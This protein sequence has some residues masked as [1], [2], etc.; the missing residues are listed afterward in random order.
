MKN[1]RHTTKNLITKAILA[2]MLATPLS[3]YAEDDKSKVE[4]LGFEV[5]TVTAQKRVQNIMNVPVTVGTISAE[6]M[7][8]SGSVRLTEMDKFIPGF[9]FGNEGITQEGVSM[10]GVESSGISI[11][12]DPSAA[13]FFD[14]VYMPRA[15]Q[16]LL[17]SDMER[18]EVL[19]GPQGTLFGRNAA[20]GVL[21]MV[22]N[23]PHEDFEATIKATLGTDNL[24]RYELMANIPLSDNVYLRTNYINTSRDGVAENI[25]MPEWNHNNKIWDAGEVAHQSA[26]ASLLWDISDNSQ[27][28]ISY[29]W[30]DLNQ[31]PPMTIGISEYA[32][33]QGDPFAPKVENDVVGGAETRDMTSATV[34]FLHE[35]NND[36]SMKYIASFR[37]WEVFARRDE[38]GTADLSRYFDTINH[39]EAD[40]FY[41]ELQFN[42]ET[43]NINSVFGF[44][45]SK[46]SAKQLTHIGLTADSAARS[47][48]ASVND[49]IK[50]GVADQLTNTL[51][52]NTDAHAAGAFGE[53]VT[54]DSVLNAIYQSSGFPIESTWHAEEWEHTLNTMGFGDTIMTAIGMPG[55]PLTAGVVTA[56]GDATYDIASVAL[57]TAE[58]FGPSHSGSFWQENVQNQGD[59]TNWGIYA[60]V[61]YMINDK[62]SI[63]GGLRYSKDE[64]EFSWLTEDSS[65]ATIRPGVSNLIFPVVD[66]KAKDSWDKVTGRLVA[67]YQVSNEHMVFG[68]YSVGYKSGGYDSLT[69]NTQAFKPED[70]VNYELGYKGILFDA[71]I[72][73]VSAYYNQLDN[74]QKGIVSKLPGNLRAIPT[75]INIDREIIGLEID[76]RWNMTE[77]AQ[78]GLVT[79]IR[80]TDIYTPSFYNG[81]GTLIEEQSTDLDAAANVTMTLDWVLDLGIGNTN[82][83]VDY[84]YIENQN[85]QEVGLEEYK[86]S[87]DAYFIDTKN[88]NARFSWTSEDD[89]LEIGLWGKNLLDKRYVYELG[90]YAADALGVPQGQI[91]RGLEAGVDV[92]YSF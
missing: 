59:F 45:Y 74:Q 25:S 46:E 30:D 12:G 85:D 39:E 6:L 27:F 81:E 47:I 21:N 62:W 77:D 8:E 26:R 73:N 80:S 90:G 40:I 5:I 72:A 71:V 36:L 9:E 70:S 17:F 44:S 11:G 28:Q 10:R 52:G 7:E 18:I 42:Y 56:T 37:E 3:A 2:S 84:V 66:L 60:D 53:G 75:I 57:G 91:N 87:V 35:F 51:G 88:L 67:S 13:T 23:R 55:Q 82:L 49:L 65:F 1:N 31:A 69:P 92:T 83:H 20:V 63:I 33:G 78:L 41:T 15:A 50:A 43:D 89:A 19:K 32:Y 24:Q 68:S 22:P 86:K 16:N 48:T 64:K 61:D 58:I 29:D 54:F 38:D 79:E 4:V 76:L 34:K 14:D